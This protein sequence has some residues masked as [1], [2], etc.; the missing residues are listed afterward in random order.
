MPSGSRLSRKPAVLHDSCSRGN[1]GSAAEGLSRARQMKHTNL[2]IIGGGPA[3]L[4]AAHEAC[5][6]GLSV[7]LLDEQ[8][9]LGGQIYRNIEQ[10]TE[11]L[12]RRAH[13]LGKDYQ[14]GEELTRIFPHSRALYIGASLVWHIETGLPWAIHQSPFTSTQYASM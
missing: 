9:S 14:H 13:V 10:V 6:R 8:T 4:A 7:C 12:P 1:A 5:S 11:R 2:A 3:G